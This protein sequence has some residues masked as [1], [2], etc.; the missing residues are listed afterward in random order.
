MKNVLKFKKKKKK[1]I[2]QKEIYY[3]LISLKLL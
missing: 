1:M 3:I 2:T